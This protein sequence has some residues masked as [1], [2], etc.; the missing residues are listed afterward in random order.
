MFIKN[1]TKNP[2]L[3]KSLYICPPKHIKNERSGFPHNSNCCSSRIGKK[4]FSIAGG[5]DRLFF[6]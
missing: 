1:L 4:Y 5:I 6:C 2:V 3:I